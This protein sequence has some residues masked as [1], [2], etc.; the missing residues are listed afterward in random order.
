MSPNAPGPE[1]AS[2]AERAEGVR[3]TLSG[4]D[5]PKDTE[6]P[7]GNTKDREGKEA[8]DGVGESI[9]RSGEAIAGAEGKEPGRQDTGT[10]DTPADRPTGTSDPRDATGVDPQTGPND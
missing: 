4:E 10:D 6:Q 9:T 1:E 8:P 5:P 2:K 7:M 3:R